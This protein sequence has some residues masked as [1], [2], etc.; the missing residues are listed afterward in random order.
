VV[1][2]EKACKKKGGGLRERDVSQRIAK[3]QQSIN[4]GCKK[5]HLELKKTEVATKREKESKRIDRRGTGGVE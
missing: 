2:E 4:A 3:I 1:P 5:T